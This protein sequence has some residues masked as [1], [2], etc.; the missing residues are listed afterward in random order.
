[1]RWVTILAAIFV[2]WAGPAHAQLPP[3]LRSA[4]ITE[5]DWRVAQEAIRRE[6]RLRGQRE[7]VVR[8]L[9]IE[10]FQAQPGQ[11]FERYVALI[12][13]G[14]QRLPAALA[15]AQALDPGNDPDLQRLKD[16][17]VRAA[18]EGRLQE[19]LRAQDEYAATLGAVLARA[20]ERPQIELAAAHA[21]GAETASALGDYA[22]AASRYERA[23]TAAPEAQPMLRWRY[24]M[25]QAQ[26]LTDRGVLF[27][28]SDAFRQALN[29]L[30]RSALPLVT[31]STAAERA[32][33]MIATA[34]VSLELAR[35]EGVRGMSH[36]EFAFAQLARAL[37]GL[38]TA[39]HPQIAA[40]FN[41]E[42]ART[43]TFLT[44]MGINEVVWDDVERDLAAASQHYNRQTHPARWADIQT[45]LGDFRIAYARRFGSRQSAV[46]SYR[47]ALAVYTQADAPRQW[48]SLQEK[49]GVALWMF[50]RDIT[51]SMAAFDAASIVRTRA[52]TPGAWAQTQL[53]RADVLLEAARSG[54]SAARE[55]AR[56]AYRDAL[57][58]FTQ[59]SAWQSW[60]N[61]SI[62]L[63]L[64][65]VMAGGRS[66]LAAAETLLNAVRGTIDEGDLSLVA[67][68]DFAM[69]R[70]RAA[71][72][73][74]AE[75]R[76]LLQAPL[77]FYRDTHQRETVREIE[78][79]ASGLPN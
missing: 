59:D 14:A 23:A 49:L 10:I 60:A 53:R 42:R 24:R 54:N 78:A 5:A 11:S 71:Q 37:D 1:M 19:A 61:A 30:G 28:D 66:D 35:E 9:A 79:F 16:R 56:A 26:A 62:G 41:I 55:Q 29:V 40:D 68:S 70:L 17:A 63:A 20:I 58:I 18:E 73:R 33:T 51:G 2:L 39:A 12:E 43:F 75:A 4:G 48:G 50:D 38:D 44:E 65:G 46:P 64:V 69:A 13:A 8:T 22:G 36:L 7:A 45:Y 76:A 72:G 47:D 15:A 77:E 57:T 52:A 67:K 34:S 21:A 3:E 6:A 25:A 31:E 27:A 32:A 74:P